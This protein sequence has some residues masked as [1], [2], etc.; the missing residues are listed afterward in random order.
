MHYSDIETARASH[1]LV[2]SFEA[3]DPQQS[4]SWRLMTS[5]PPARRSHCFPWGTPQMDGRFV[6]WKIPWKWMMTGGTLI[7]GNFHLT[8]FIQVLIEQLNS[9]AQLFLADLSGTYSG[10]KQVDIK[11]TRCTR[12]NR[13]SLIVKNQ[14]LTL[15]GFLC[16]LN[17]QRPWTRCQ[18]FVFGLSHKCLA[19]ACS[20]SGGS[21]VHGSCGAICF[22]DGRRRFRGVVVL[23]LGLNLS[24]FTCCD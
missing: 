6:S 13:I 22:A 20:I 7:L 18:S 14:L 1:G 16:E 21:S 10:T 5:A 19:A 23:S 15:Q 17:R 4:P 9:T 24:S 3:L 2:T 8:S 12:R 11:C